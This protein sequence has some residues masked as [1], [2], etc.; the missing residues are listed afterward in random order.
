MAQGLNTPPRAKP[1]K[2]PSSSRS[3]LRHATRLVHQVCCLAGS[4]TLID[5]IRRTGAPDTLG[6]LIEKLDTPALFNWLIDTLSYQGISD[7]VAT[8]YIYEH[9]SITWAEI[10]YR[11]SKRPS[12]PKLKSYWHFH[13]CRYSKSKRTCASPEHYSRCPVPKHRLRNGRLN[14]TAY[15]LFLFLRDIADCDLVNWIDARLSQVASQND[16]VPQ[17]VAA[18]RESLL[19]PLRHVYGVADKVLSMALASILLAAQD[20][21]THWHETGGSMVAVDGLVHAWL[22]RTG[23]LASLNAEHPYGP[24][25]YGKDGCSEII[26]KI[27]LRID[28]RQFNKSFPTFFCRAVQFAVWRFCAQEMLNICNGNRID[29]RMRCQND[30]CGLYG[31]CARQPIS[32]LNK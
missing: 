16:R 6:S 28:V 18:M 13:G 5:D 10:E 15:S 14:Q 26:E 1:K 2:H 19:G 4:H 27:A 29:D 12:C 30:W 21:R 20:G 3:A 22:H 31:R 24:R 25:C 8:A 7:R 17:Y 23:I 9:G 11:L 32:P